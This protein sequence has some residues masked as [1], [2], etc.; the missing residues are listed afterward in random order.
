[1]LINELFRLNNE[2]VFFFLVLKQCRNFLALLV[3]D[4]LAA[5]NGLDFL[6]QSK[7]VLRLGGGFGNRG[8]N[9]KLDFGLG[10]LIFRSV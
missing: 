3:V 4:V 8:Y 10:F 7:F 2:V 1:M 5:Q 9:F 6:F